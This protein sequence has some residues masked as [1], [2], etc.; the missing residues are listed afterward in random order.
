MVTGRQK[1]I[2]LAILAAGVVLFYLLM[3]GDADRVKGQFEFL[4]DNITKSAGENQLIGAANSKRIRS[5]F[6]ET[7]TIDAPAYDY[8]RDLPAAELPA[9]VLTARKPYMELALDFYDFTID[10]PQEEKASVRV[11]ARLRGRLP[12]GEAVEDIQELNCRLLLFEDRWRFAVIEFVAVL[13]Q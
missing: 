7:V 8:V 10:F 5:A 12:S 3:P 4:A 11:T 1:T 13:E 2:A 6:M 9:L